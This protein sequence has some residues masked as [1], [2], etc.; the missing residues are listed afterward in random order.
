MLLLSED[1]GLS[2]PEAGWLYGLH[3]M[4]IAVLTIPAGFLIDAVGLRVSEDRDEISV[5]VL[6]CA[7]GWSFSSRDAELLAV[8][9]ST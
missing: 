8:N 1:F 9:S 7:Q 4:S 2:D 5:L 6:I 3:G